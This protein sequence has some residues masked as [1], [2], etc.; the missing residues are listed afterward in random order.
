[1]DAYIHVCLPTTGEGIQMEEICAGAQV[2]LTHT[3]TLCKLHAGVDVRYLVAQSKTMLVVLHQS[4]MLRNC[5]QSQC[6][7]VLNHIR[8]S[9][10][11]DGKVWVRILVKG[12]IQ[13]RV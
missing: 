4:S 6:L 12:S 9:I 5:K 1:M 7:V 13:I 3:R 10:D 11:V 2:F 8:H